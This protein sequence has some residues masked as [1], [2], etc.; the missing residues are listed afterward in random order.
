MKNQEVL[1]GCLGIFKSFHI[2]RVTRSVFL[3]PVDKRKPDRQDIRLILMCGCLP[4]P[5]GAV[6]LPDS[7][8][9]ADTFW[10]AESNQA[11]SLSVCMSVSCTWRSPRPS[12]SSSRAAER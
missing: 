12:G 2:F 6:V 9:I 1:S 7:S 4:V 8:A 11:F 10:A 3:K 5:R